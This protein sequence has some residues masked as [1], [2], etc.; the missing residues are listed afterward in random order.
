MDPRYHTTLA[1]LGQR[2][3]DYPAATFDQR[4]GPYQAPVDQE[5]LRRLFEL[6]MLR[7]TPE[8]IVPGTRTWPFGYTQ[9]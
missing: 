7:Q 9:T 4:F 6:Q 3:Q 5:M 8:S 1:N 2:Y